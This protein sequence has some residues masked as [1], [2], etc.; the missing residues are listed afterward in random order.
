MHRGDA[1]VG[2]LNTL[3]QERLNPAREGL[4]EARGGGRVYRPGDRVL[5]LKNDYTL[6]VFNGDLGTVAA[7]DQAEQEVGLAL[8]DGRVVRYP[9][10]SLYALTHAY[11]ISIHKSQGA[12]FPA[13]VIPLV[14]AHA[15]LLG[16]TLLYT[17]FT[18]ARQL[19]VIVGQQRALSMAVR[20]WRRAPRYTALGGLLDGTTR[21]AWGARAG[22]RGGR[23]GRRRRLV[24][25]AGRCG[26][27]RLSGHALRPAACPPRWPTARRRRRHEGPAARCPRRR[28]ALRADPAGRRGRARRAGRRPPRCCAGASRRGRRAPRQRTASDR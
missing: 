9:F 10:A 15:A 24:G 18:R 11:A 22:R 14:T 3:L 27:R 17:A 25:R 5:Q 19:V 6:D 2:A 16:R 26:G 4:P 8:D 12:E 23:S 20:D 7:I 13:V 1:G 21:Y 28:H